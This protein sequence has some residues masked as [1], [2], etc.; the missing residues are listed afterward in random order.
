MRL[1]G[2]VL[3]ISLALAPFVAEAQQRGKAPAIGILSPWPASESTTGPD[4]F[5]RALRDLGYTERDGITFEYRSFAG[6]DDRLPMLAAE[7]VALKV[8]VMV[9]A[10]IPAIRAAQRASATIPI[11]MM[12]SSDPVRLG[13]VQSLPRPGGN[14]TGVASLLFDLGAKRVELLREASPRLSRLAVLFNP[15]NPAIRD[16]ASQTESAA[17]TLGVRARLFEIREPTDFG[18]TFAAILRG[19]SDGLIV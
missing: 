6:H 12:W 10:T 16:G 4:A 5:R 9:A 3:A 1:I 14:T 13:L 15:T 19:R 18:A 2:L 8:D 11:V 17:R 7:L